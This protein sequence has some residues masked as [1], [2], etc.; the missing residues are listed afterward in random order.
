M[1][2]HSQSHYKTSDI[3][4]FSMLVVLLIVSLSGCQSAVRWSMVEEGALSPQSSLTG[5][6]S[7]PV[8]PGAAHS[9]AATVITLS[10]CVLT[11]SSGDRVESPQEDGAGY[12]GTS[13]EK[14]PVKSGSTKK[15][16]FLRRSRLSVEIEVGKEEVHRQVGI[17]TEAFDAAAWKKY[18]RVD[19]GQEP[20]LPKNIEDILDKKAPFLLEDE[21][22]PQRVCDNHLL[23]LL[24][25]EVNGEAF[26]LDKLGELIL[27]YF[28][29]NNKQEL[30]N[31]SH[32]YGF[33]SGYLTSE[34]RTNPPSPSSYWLLLPKTILE[35]SRSKSFSEQKNMVSEYCSS[36]YRLPRA[37][38]V[39]TSLLSH[40][41]RSG[42]C[43]YAHANSQGR[44]TYARCSDL[45]KDGDS[46]V[47]G[48]FEPSGL[49]IDSN[50]GDHRSP[51]GVS[52]CREF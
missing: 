49:H 34:N 10:P 23:T 32:G 18:F 5:I 1:I 29:D 2:I 17:P 21:K 22:S 4:G 14:F 27:P 38:E 36:G 45:D 30:G 44:W 20:P 37:L 52:C 6:P 51:G 11:A 26:T 15:S 12:V 16:K 19:V 8:Q 40:Y 24:P 35:G 50:F 48:G 25:A 3:F 33:Y 39:A 28:P 41:M 43:L 7:I 42:K 13:Q 31:N 9:F 47:V 46:L